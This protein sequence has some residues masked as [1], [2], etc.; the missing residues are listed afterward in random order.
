M[1]VRHSG[2]RTATVRNV[3]ADSQAARSLHLALRGPMA[4]KNHLSAQGLLTRLWAAS[5][6]EVSPL[7]PL[8]ACHPK[9]MCV[10]PTL[11]KKYSDQNSALKENTH[12][13]TEGSIWGSLLF[14]YFIYTSSQTYRKLFKKH[15]F[16]KKHVWYVTNS[17]K[18]GKYLYT[19]T[20]PR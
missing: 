13:H 4:D 8:V 15:N 5:A 2:A 17:V 18:R 12:T 20:L 9:H 6:T 7:S 19:C 3:E 10:A 1:L 11:L 14:L 16:T